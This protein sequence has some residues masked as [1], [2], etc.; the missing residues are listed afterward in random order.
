MEKNVSEIHSNDLYRKSKQIY[1]LDQRNMG[2]SMRVERSNVDQ[3]RKR[4]EMNKAKQNQVVKEYSFEER[5]KE[6]KEEVS[7]KDYIRMF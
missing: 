4:I 1:G 7:L 6:A 3:D 5:L 2:M